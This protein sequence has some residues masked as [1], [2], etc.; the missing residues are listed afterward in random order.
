MKLTIK[1]INNT[2]GVDTIF[3]NEN[4]YTSI[5]TIQLIKE[6][7]LLYETFLKTVK[8]FAKEKLNKAVD[9]IKDWKDAAVVFSKILSNG[10]LLNDFL[11]P[12]ERLV[13]KQLK[14]L[15]DVLEKIKL[16]S[17]VTKIKGFFKKIASLKGWKKL[18]TLIALGGVA[19]YASTKLPLDGVKKWITD[20]VGPDFIET[21]TSKLVDWKSYIG[22]IGPIVGGGAIIFKL[23][24]P[25]LT[26]FK[27]ALKS[28]SYF[29]TKIIKENK[30]RILKQLIRE[31]IFKT[32]S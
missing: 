19:F 11:Y 3:L 29:A 2:L 32:L 9:T 4:N 7:Q 18:F 23:L 13:Q 20:T 24:E 5:E 12:L 27:E 28:S 25:L 1:H 10:E 16:N 31:E 17:I 30:K 8:S 21:I 6:E 15:Y 14:K 22:F 26:K